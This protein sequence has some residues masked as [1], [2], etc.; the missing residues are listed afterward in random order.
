MILTKAAKPKFEEHPLVAASAKCFPTSIIKVIY[1]LN[2]YSNNL[3]N[4][5]PLVIFK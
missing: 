2:Y 3:V 1:F 5:S 4:Q